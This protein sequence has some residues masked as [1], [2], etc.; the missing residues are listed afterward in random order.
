MC[1]IVLFTCMLGYY[2]RAVP[3]EAEGGVSNPL[4][5][6]LQRTVSPHVSARNQIWVL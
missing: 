5:V 3:T 4:G 2:M 1:V 6:E